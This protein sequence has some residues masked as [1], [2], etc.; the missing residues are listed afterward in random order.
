MHISNT[1]HTWHS[2]FYEYMQCIVLEASELLPASRPQLK[3]FIQAA[4][5][6]LLSTA[7]LL[8]LCNCIFGDQVGL[9]RPQTWAIPWAKVVVSV[10]GCYRRGRPTSPL[11]TTRSP[12]PRSPPWRLRRNHH[13]KPPAHL[14]VPQRGTSP[15]PGNRDLAVC[16][17]DLYGPP[18]AVAW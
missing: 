1:L 15:S 11:P 5:P 6:C 7:K 10:S 14:A 8:Q 18:S 17:A 3:S 9:R 13:V 12:R 16:S 4:R 2:D